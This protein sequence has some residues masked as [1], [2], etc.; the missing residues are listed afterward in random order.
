MAGG[1]VCFKLFT[2]VVEQQRRATKTDVPAF[3]QKE[4]C[5]SLPVF[6][7]P[8]NSD[9]VYRNDKHSIIGKYDNNFFGLVRIVIQKY[10][11]GAW[12]DQVIV[13]D[14]SYGSF[15]GYGTLGS[16]DGRLNYVALVA[17]WLLIL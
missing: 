16:S 4:C 15:Y 14:N 5:F 12:E 7:D 8:S 6:A 3:P 11:N 2:K 13:G 10:V 9:D 17:D 1:E